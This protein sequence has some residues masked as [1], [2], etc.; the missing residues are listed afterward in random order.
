MN[1]LRSLLSQSPAE[2]ESFADELLDRMTPV[3]SALGLLFLLVVIGERMARAGST[4]AMLLALLGW[5]LWGAFIGEFAVRLAVAPHRGRFL[6]RN[7]WQIVFLLLPFLRALRLVRS[8]RLLRSGRVLSSTVR[9][10]RSASRVL[11]NRVTWVALV[12][13]LV[14]LAGSELLYGF[15]VYQTYAEAL[16]AAALAAISGVPLEQE[17]AYAKVVEVL[18]ALYSVAV[19]AALA[20]TVGAYFVDTKDRPAHEAGGTGGPGP[21]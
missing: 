17:D 2:R 20:A 21:T 10:S 1:R 11:G 9:S 18:L 13:A 7:W 12:S 4:A 14:I 3:M 5:L 19:F 8:F 6:R 16:H 15:G